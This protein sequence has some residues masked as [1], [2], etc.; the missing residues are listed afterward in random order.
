[1]FSLLQRSCVLS[2]MS[3]DNS[4]KIEGT[5]DDFEIVKEDL[6][7]RDHHLD[8]P[9]S[10]SYSD[11][12]DQEEIKA[13]PVLRRSPRKKQLSREGDGKQ[14][15]ESRQTTLSF[16]RRSPRKRPSSDE[17]NSATV[18]HSTTVKR[19]R[20]SSC[21]VWKYMTRPTPNS[22]QCNVIVSKDK[23][24]KEIQCGRIIK[25]STTTYK[26]HLSHIH[27]IFDPNQTTEAGGVDTTSGE[28][29]KPA[30]TKS[31]TTNLVQQ[32]LHAVGVRPGRQHFI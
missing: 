21:Y 25:G 15:K 32:P 14:K 8:H 13:T 29:S 9:S 17:E 10:S 28:V 1:M 11:E 20:S 4:H 12:S 24:G 16:P 6:L 22:A 31:T 19:A 5:A 26:Y 30:S 3:D 18:S 7:N 23:S 27:N 2:K